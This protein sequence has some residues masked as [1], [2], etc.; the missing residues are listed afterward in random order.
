M[1]RVPGLQRQHQHCAW[2]NSVR[3]G[4]R[5]TLDAAKSE[6]EF[7]DSDSSLLGTGSSASVY[8]G[9][10]NGRPVAVKVCRRTLRRLQ[11]A[12]PIALWERMPK[13]RCR[14]CVRPEAASGERSAAYLA[15]R[16]SGCRGARSLHERRCPLPFASPSKRRRVHAVARRR[17][18][19]GL[20][21][22]SATCNASL[23]S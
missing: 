6:I 21:R 12:A 18:P 4:R 2:G 7:D 16:R 1:P 20:V 8:R 11:L 17:L 10:L 9:K 14:S 3:A 15:C 23:S 22:Y 19:W 13:E 5:Y